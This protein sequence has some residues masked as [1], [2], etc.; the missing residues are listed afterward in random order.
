MVAFQC[1]EAQYGAYDPW[2]H[3]MT[4][5]EIYREVSSEW[6]GTIANRYPILASMNIFD[7]FDAPFGICAD[8]KAACRQAERLTGRRF[9]IL[10]KEKDDNDRPVTVQVKRIG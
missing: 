5:F 6:A 7:A 9:S 2:S 4:D 8:L 1:L 3:E 10:V